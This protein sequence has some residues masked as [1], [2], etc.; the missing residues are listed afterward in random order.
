MEERNNNTGLVVLITVLV[1]LVL[2]LV[3]FIVYDKVIDKENEPNTEENNNE[4]SNNQGNENQDIVVDYDLDKAKKL[5][6]KY[7]YNYRGMETTFEKMS[8]NDK[9]FIAYTKLNESD[10]GVANCKNL[11]AGEGN[12]AGGYYIDVLGNEYVCNEYSKTIAYNLI[13]SAYKDLFG[14]STNIPKKSFAIGWEAI[15]YVQSTN[16]FVDLDFYGGGDW[17]ENQPKYGVISAKLT[18]DNNLV[19]EVGYVVFKFDFDRNLYYADFDKN[20]TYTSVDDIEEDFFKQNLDEVKVLK[21]NFEKE[22]NKFVLKN[23]EA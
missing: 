19:V 20:I 15:G 3:G 13:N 18:N 6:D 4:S 1:M 23:M 12:D 7:Y 2:G 16:E 8:E 22:N 10:F 9:M 5:V 11:Y 14:N 21:F 17:P